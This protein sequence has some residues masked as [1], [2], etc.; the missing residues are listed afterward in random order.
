MFFVRYCW[1]SSLK[2]Q[3]AIWIALV[4]AL[5]SAHGT[6]AQ[7]E[8]FAVSHQSRCMQEPGSPA[9]ELCAMRTIQLASQLHGLEFGDQVAEAL[10]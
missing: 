3:V 5:A 7:A 4:A 9:V 8:E 2:V 6:S 10:R 1:T